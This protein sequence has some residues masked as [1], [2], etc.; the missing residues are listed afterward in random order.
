MTYFFTESNG[1]Q[2]FFWFRVKTKI[3]MQKKEPLTRVAHMVESEANQRTK[4]SKPEDEEEVDKGLEKKQKVLATTRGL[5]SVQD[6]HQRLPADEEEKAG[7]DRYQEKGIPR[8]RIVPTLFAAEDPV[9]LDFDSMCEE[10][11]RYKGTPPK[12][13]FRVGN[14]TVAREE[15]GVDPERS[16]V[17][18][19][20]WDWLGTD[21]E[22]MPAMIHFTQNKLGHIYMDIPGI[23]HFKIRIPGGPMRTII[24]RRGSKVRAELR[25]TRSFKRSRFKAYEWNDDNFPSES[26]NLLAYI[27]ARIEEDDTMYVAEFY[28]KAGDEGAEPLMNKSERLMLKGSGK[29][30]MCNTL[31]TISGLTFVYLM[32]MG[33]FPS[34]RRELLDKAETMSR[35][36]FLP[37]IIRLKEK[38]ERRKLSASELEALEK[39]YQVW[40]PQPTWV[41]ELTNELLIEYYTKQYGFV[42]NREDDNTWE[43]GKFMVTSYE[44]LINHCEGRPMKREEEM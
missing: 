11:E 4:R 40:H 29:R 8:R 25:A 10:W 5:E 22:Y 3:N 43:R 31:R 16:S 44:D 9:P 35:H 27:S 21:M 17:C 38:H 28:S 13:F 39:Y 19:Q 14:F 26:T 7:S 37:D 42:L 2:F 34:H 30:L 18:R 20:F 32:P 1:M 24:Q 15:A 41:D 36:E 6:V 12:V 23:T 33:S